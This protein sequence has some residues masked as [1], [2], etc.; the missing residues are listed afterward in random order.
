M[1]LNLL[2]KMPRQ[3]TNSSIFVHLKFIDQ[4][5][6][7]RHAVNLDLKL[8]DVVNVRGEMNKMLVSFQV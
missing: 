8:E 3:Q 2:L 5:E 6:G 4:K 7:K 1:C